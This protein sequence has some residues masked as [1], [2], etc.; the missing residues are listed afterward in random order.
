MSE[1]GFG[2]ALN[3]DG[4]NE[5]GCTS[6]SGAE[7][8]ID[9]TEIARRLGM[10]VRTVDRLVKRGELPQPCIGQGGRPRWLWSYVVDFCLQQH[11]RQNKLDHRLKHKL[12]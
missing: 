3:I 8:L 9:R 6:E 1:E 11:H 10:N 7:V 5:T 2:K 4:P 12:K